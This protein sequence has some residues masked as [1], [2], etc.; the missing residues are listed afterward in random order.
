MTRIPHFARPVLVLTTAGVALSTALSGCGASHAVA[1]PSPL[2][3]STAAPTA[4]P[5]SQTPLPAATTTSASTPPRSVVAIARGTPSKPVAPAPA[6]LLVSRLVGVGSARQVISVTA[7]GY[8][9]SYATVQAF[10]RTATGW[11]QS[12]GPWQARIGTAGFAPSGM[13][14]EGD[15]RTPTGSYGFDFFFGVLAN[16][17][18]RYS[19]RPI[20]SAS[21]VWDDDPSSPAY[22]EWVDTRTGS[23]GRSPEPMDNVPVYDYGAVI[24]YNESR[25]PGLG[26]AI[27]LHQNGSGSTAGCV[28]LPQS[29]LLTLLRWLDPSQVPRIIM[30]TTAAI[31]S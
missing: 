13:K 20:T 16:P 4:L 10:T 24:A 5:S 31:T 29:E 27:F 28:S 25:T 18:V 26:S 8:G 17:G 12:F 21:I 23:A 30:G 1:V 19:Y 6:P 15:D 3:R 22:N 11:V 2:P 14:R 7:T 9:T